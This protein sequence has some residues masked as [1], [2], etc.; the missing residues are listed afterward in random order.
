[1]KGVIAIIFTLG[2]GHC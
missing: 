2:K 1:M